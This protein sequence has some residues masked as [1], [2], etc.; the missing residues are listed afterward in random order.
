MLKVTGN[1]EAPVRLPVQFTRGERTPLAVW[2]GRQKLLRDPARISAALEG[3]SALKALFD[4]LAR[5]ASSGQLPARNVIGFQLGKQLR[6]V[7]ERMS[8]RETVQALCFLN[9]LSLSATVKGWIIRGIFEARGNGRE[10]AEAFVSHY[11]YSDQRPF[12]PDCEDQLPGPRTELLNVFLNDSGEG[13]TQNLIGLRKI[14]PTIRSV[15]TPNQLLAIF[16]TIKE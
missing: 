16:Y 15:R 10:M 2:L 12:E 6:P 8:P 14:S 13:L 3:D 1:T 5:T 7:M 4:G 11:R 9:G